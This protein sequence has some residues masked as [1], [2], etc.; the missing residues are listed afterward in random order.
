MRRAC[1]AAAFSSSLR[2]E[3]SSTFLALRMLDVHALP[4]THEPTT[5]M[6]FSVSV[7]VLSEQM[8]VQLLMVSHALSLRTRFLSSNIC[9]IE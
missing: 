8:L 7:P 9:F 2:P 6:R 3:S 4:A 5:V 1:S